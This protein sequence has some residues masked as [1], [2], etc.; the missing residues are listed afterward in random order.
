MLLVRIFLSVLVMVRSKTIH[1]LNLIENWNFFLM[2]TNSSANF[3]NSFKHIKNSKNNHTNKSNKNYYFYTFKHSLNSSQ[4]SL[5]TCPAIEQQLLLLALSCINISLI[6]YFV[7]Q[8]LLRR[9]PA[10]IPKIHGTKNIN[11]STCRLSSFV[12]FS[13]M[14]GIIANLDE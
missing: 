13:N 1:L 2:T 3:Q 14:D 12:C 4:I 5:T 6:W 11:R 7:F 9:M 8:H 10:G